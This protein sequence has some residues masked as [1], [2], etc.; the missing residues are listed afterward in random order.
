MTKRP[1]SSTGSAFTTWASRSQLAIRLW[2][3]ETGR[4]RIAAL[5]VRVD[6]HAA[7]V[8]LTGALEVALVIELLDDLKVRSRTDDKS[9]SCAA[10][11]PPSAAG[12]ASAI[13]MAILAFFTPARRAARGSG[14]R[15]ETL[16]SCERN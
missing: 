6:A 4:G 1:R 15:C 13:P 10:A 7:L 14:I 2:R 8:S 12:T 3:D 5:A 9:E 16:L 11:Q